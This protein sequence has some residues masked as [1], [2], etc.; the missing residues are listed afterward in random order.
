MQNITVALNLDAVQQIGKNL[1]LSLFNQFMFYK[2][3]PHISLLRD[4]N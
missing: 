3:N 2:P 4:S 1:F